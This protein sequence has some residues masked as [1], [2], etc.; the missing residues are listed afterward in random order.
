[1]S[2]GY[3]IINSLENRAV[4]KIFTKYNGV[5]FAHGFQ[6]LRKNSFQVRSFEKEFAKRLG[7]NG[8]LAVSSGTMAQFVAMKALGCR[9][10]DE[11]ITQAFTFVATVEVILALGCVPVLTECDESLNMDP[12]DLEQKITKKTKL[13]IPVHMLGQAAD[14]NS[15]L[16]ISRRF[17]IPVL[18]DACEALGGS[19]RGRP[20]GTLGDCGVFSLDFAKTITTGE[21]GVI[22]FKKKPL[23]NKAREFHDHGHINQ[24]NKPRG[25][26]RRRFPGLNLRITEMQGA[27][28]RVQLKK[29]NY[30]IKNQNKNKNQL[31]KNIKTVFPKITTRKYND[32]HGDCGDTL[33]LDLK[34]EKSAKKFVKQFVMYKYSTKNIPDA[35]NW[36]FAGYFDNMFANTRYEKNYKREWP[37]TEKVLRRM[38]AIPISCK[39]TPQQLKKISKAV[40]SCLEKSQ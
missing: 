22:L 24:K 20:L 19:Y 31:L 38:V 27:V 1:M 28:G 15:I 39:W 32:K 9:P 8:A 6:Q 17:K 3:E 12:I 25:L 33:I 2:P 29:L 26:D 23:L 5:L 10:G 35:L 30:I 11:I 36:H 40:V 13:I 37:E 21:G 18:E 14:M 16:K 34:S 4:Q 7:V